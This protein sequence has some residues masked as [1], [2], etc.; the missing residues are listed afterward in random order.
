M[1]VK[2]L[3]LLCNAHLDPVWQWEWEEGAAEALATF[4]TAARLCREFD[5]FIFNHNEALLYEWVERYDPTLFAE[6]RALVA[7]G[8]WHIMGGWFLQPDCNMPAG[9]LIARQ[10]TYGRQYFSEKFGVAPRVA[11][12]FDSFGHSRGLVQLLARSGFTGYLHCRPY[13]MKT[14]LPAPIYRWVGYDGSS[15][16]GHLM[17]FYNSLIGQA[18]QKIS[19]WISEHKDAS[20]GFMPWGIGDH[21]GGPSR[22]DL[23]KIAAM[24]KSESSWELLHS[25]PEAFF[26]ELVER[27]HPLPE[28]A[29]D[30]NNAMIGC[31]T[32]QMRLKRGYRQ[33]EG[34]YLSVEKMC[35]TASAQG[36]MVYPTE[37]LRE[38]LKDILML[39]FHDILP[40]TSVESAEQYALDLIGR[41]T[42]HLRELRAE[43]FFALSRGELSV[44]GEQYCILVYNPHPY[45]IESQIECELMLIDQNWALEYSVPVVSCAGEP[46]AAQAIKEASNLNLDWRKRVCLRGTL[47]PSGL[48]RFDCRMEKTPQRFASV[49]LPAGEPFVFENDAMRVVINT[50]TGLIDEYCVDGQSYLAPGACDLLLFDDDDDTWAMNVDR[51]GEVLERSRLMTRVE[52]ARLSGESGS[53]LGPLRIV[54]D[55][56]VCVVV[57][58]MLR[59]GHSDVIQQYILPRKG[60]GFEIET[61]VIWSET[62][63]MLKLALPTTLQ[64]PTLQ[65]QV[66]FGREELPCDGREQLAQRWHALTDTNKIHTLSV[67]NDAPYG[68]D[69]SEGTLRLSLLR[70]TAY[71]GHP[72]PA[73]TGEEGVGA[74]SDGQAT[75][76]ILAQDRYYPRLDQGPQ[77]FRFRIEGG[78]SEERLAGVEREAQY[79]NEP[80]Y[81]LSFNPPGEGET[82]LRG[83][84][85]SNPAV[86][87]SA[88]KR[89]DDGRGYV[90]RL[91][92]PNGNVAQ[93]Q[94]SL[95]ALGIEHAVAL[96]A[97]EIK[98][99]RIDD[100]T[101]AIR[102]VMLTEEDPAN[103]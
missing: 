11:L 12:N 60:S 53:T 87:L 96:D 73:A 51:F 47:A 84:E 57:E 7:E 102:E 2:R 46:V 19:G 81:A 22:E 3:H 1:P 85:L 10:I 88:F 77:C 43:A 34:L 38:A 18:H 5:G 23:R 17:P 49:N 78:A 68:C 83:P 90:V 6:I 63:R 74:D 94:L 82:A 14:P 67:I 31:Y 26:D 80:A 97:F 54:E 55:G 91:F 101:R 27:E 35:A 92:E 58:A 56:P 61:R 15:V 28:H 99:L 21:G 36:L 64:T 76:P 62:R 9:E 42:S 98:T 13:E 66:I 8:R 79:H 39:Q 45:A 59:V 37:R 24:M 103:D 29:A 65:A 41:S 48:T 93:T 86:T 4:R 30:L 50:G 71:T 95:P 40:G 69:C 72:I 25:T 100:E 70:A 89:S 52:A 33:L 20:I 16:I 75:R 44:E 32:S